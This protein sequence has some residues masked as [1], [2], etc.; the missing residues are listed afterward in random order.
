[1]RRKRGFR[2]SRFTKPLK[3]VVNLGNK[4]FDGVKKTVKTVSG[5]VGNTLSRTS[6]FIFGCSSSNVE[7]R[8]KLIAL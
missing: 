1:M 3:R 8:G 7:I 5:F 2:L 4:V 6:C